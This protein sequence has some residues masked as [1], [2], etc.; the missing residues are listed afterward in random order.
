MFAEIN[1]TSVD[2]KIDFP[3]SADYGRVEVARS[4]T[5]QTDDLFGPITAIAIFV[6]MKRPRL[7]LDKVYSPLVK[8][9]GLPI[10]MFV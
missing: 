9:I 5:S 6:L 10:V 3:V 8:T 1:R 2:I 7:G 4:A